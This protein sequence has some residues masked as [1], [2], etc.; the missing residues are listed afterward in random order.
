MQLLSLASY[1]IL[2]LGAPAAP[3]QPALV[4]APFVRSLQQQLDGLISEA[5]YPGLTLG[6]ALA[7]GTSGSLAAGFA[8]LEERLPMRPNDVMLT[9]SV[10]KIF[11]AAVILQLVQEHKLALDDPIATWI[12]GEDWFTRLPNGAAISLR[13]LLNHSSGIPRYVF[14]KA[15]QDDLLKDAERIWKPR[16]LVAYILDRPGLFPAGEGFAYADTNYLLLGMIIEKVTGD[17]YYNQVRARL[18]AGF[19]AIHPSDSLHVPGLVP[20]YAGDQD[21]LGFPPKMVIAG[22]VQANIQF[23]WTGGGYAVAVEDLARFAKKLYEGGY[24]EEAIMREMFT[25]VDAPQIHCRY[26][27]GVMERQ[28]QGRKA[29]GHDGFMPGY[30]SFLNYFPDKKI[31][32][33]IQIN[34]TDPSRLGSDLGRHLQS[35]HQT[36]LDEI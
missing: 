17:R 15:F 31:A 19:S 27:L 33:A 9:G 30:L 20:G 11:C 1:V 28:G 35:L 23:E 6:Y 25:T 12:G 36:I 3:A 8:D 22:K 10:G 29:Y 18:L 16:E 7:D 5:G 24:H 32:V 2:A 26:G 14:E 4:E 21:P 13:M 34:T